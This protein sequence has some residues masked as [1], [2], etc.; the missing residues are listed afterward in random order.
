M[1]LDIIHQSWSRTWKPRYPGRIYD[2]CHKNAK[3]GPPYT[4]TGAFDV[5][6]TRHMMAL[7]DSF[8]DVH[9]RETNVLAP[10]RGAK[11]LFADMSHLYVMSERPAPTLFAFQDDKAAKDQAELRTWANIMRC[12]A[13][14]AQLST[15]RHKNRIC[16]IILPNMVFHIR[17][18]ADSNFQSRG[19]QNVWLD[20]PWQYKEGKIEE[21]RGRLGDF[22]K[23]QNDKL[24][25]LSQGGFAD[26]DWD[27]QYN[28]GVIHEWFVQCMACGHYMQPRWTG[29]RADG[30]TW[31]MKW[32]PH[33]LSNGL[34]DIVKVLP[35]IRY[36]CEKCGHPH[37]WCERTKLEWNRTGKYTAEQT[38]EK[39]KSKDS[40]H[41]TAV[42]DYPWDQ[43][44]DMYLQ[45][46]NAWKQGNATPLI[47]FFQKRMAEMASEEKLLQ[48]KLNF[49][50]ARYEIKSKPS[51]A[52]RILTADRQD[53][54]VYWVTARDWW[55][56]GKSRRV[57]F[58]KKFSTEDIE[59]LRE[60]LEIEPNKVLIDSGFKPKSDRGVYAACI[61]YGWVPVKG[62][63]T[64]GGEEVFFTHTV[65]EGDRHYPVQRTYKGIDADAELGRGAE[66][67]LILIKFS[68]PTYA[69]RLLGLI[70]RGLWQ[71][72][73]GLESD[74]MDREYK[75]Q[76]SA[77]FKR[78]IEVGNK[79]AKKVKHIFVCPSKNNHAFDCSKIQVLAATLLDILPDL[80]SQD[81]A[82]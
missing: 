60:E 70:D 14:R 71:E 33:K 46:I 82:R 34:W 73:E 23:M 50:K 67:I 13:V 32:N 27:R 21:A 64:E 8:E 48:N 10:V 65:R 63:A 59:K 25:C 44:V 36:E 2:W 24:I 37:L 11:T 35:T 68:S 58:W 4:K 80:E 38:N 28:R 17:G 20:E 66:D 12:D 7:F 31:G 47:Q 78:A 62:V 72:P 49:A 6:E 56:G 41:W 53:E 69:D 45:A 39:L 3:L 9:K 61:K 40:F 74:P 29:H 81:V 54:D 52:I 18:P 51:D 57:G 75:I 16:D 19:Y 42:I 26:S 1:G 22:A 43:L 55:V 77:E 5:S 30:T 76:M 79:L 15:N